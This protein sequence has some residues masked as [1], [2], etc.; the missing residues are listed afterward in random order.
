VTDFELSGAAES[1]TISTVRTDPYIDP[2]TEDVYLS[3]TAIVTLSGNIGLGDYAYIKVNSDATTYNKQL[4][5]VIS[6]K[7]YGGV[8]LNDSIETNSL[9][10][11]VYVQAKNITFK[12]GIKNDEITISGAL[13]DYAK[14]E[15]VEVVTSSLVAIHLS[16]P[17]TYFRK[18]ETDEN[19]SQ[20]ISSDI[21]KF[22]FASTTNDEGVAFDCTSY[23]ATPR[24]S[25]SIEKDGK[26]VT[27]SLTLDYGEFN[28][29]DLYSFTLTD[30]LEN[31]ILTSNVNTVNID[32]SLTISFTVPDSY[33]NYS[34]ILYF[35][36][37][38][39]YDITNS[40]GETQSITIRTPLYI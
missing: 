1:L 2:D 9:S 25:C 16:F 6:T 27:I 17:Y 13:E 33:K 8:V 35:T 26:N 39:A 22:S 23:V 19:G 36:I 15:K 12:Q 28:M 21:G 32:E 5:V 3:Q 10:D 40:E 14:I 20:S 31:E 34:G 30:E 29:L 4:S 7:S 37:E 24:V 11:V 18:L 38:G